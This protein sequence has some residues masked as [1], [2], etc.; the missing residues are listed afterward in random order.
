MALIEDFR[1]C[2]LDG[3]LEGALRL[4]QQHSREL[5][6]SRV[7]GM[8]VL[9]ILASSPQ[10][11]SLD[12]SDFV[13]AERFLE[14]VSL[15]EK[16]VEGQVLATKIK[17]PLKLAVE[18]SNCNIVWGLSR[19]GVNDLS[20]R[21]M[22]QIASTAP[23]EEVASC[24]YESYCFALLRSGKKNIHK[25]YEMIKS[26]KVSSQA[27]DWKGRGVFHYISENGEEY[28]SRLF[29]KFTNLG[30]DI[31]KR[32]KK[33]ETPL[34]VAVVSFF[35]ARPLIQSFKPGNVVALFME[36]ANF[37]SD[38]DGVTPI[39]KC[40]T[41]EKKELLASLVILH[42]VR[43]GINLD[44][45]EELISKYS[46]FITY[47][48]DDE[49]NVLHC[50]VRHISE[51]D[52]D[53][54]DKFYSVMR[55]LVRKLPIIDLLQHTNSE[56][57]TSMHMAASF[58]DIRSLQIM[59]EAEG[60]AVVSSKFLD[61]RGNTLLHSAIKGWCVSEY[62]ISTEQ[63][64]DV[65]DFLCEWDNSLLNSKNGKGRTPLHIA[66]ASN[67]AL[68]F[69][70]L[71]EMGASTEIEDNIGL[72]ALEMSRI[73]TV[74]LMME[75][76][77]LG[78]VG[79]FIENGLPN[80]KYYLRMGLSL[81]GSLSDGRT[82]L[83][84]ITDVILEHPNKIS[85]GVNF[86]KILARKGASTTIVDLKGRV[87]LPLSH[88]E[89]LAYAANGDIE[90]VLYMIA[91]L[92]TLSEVRD[93]KGNGIFHYI[94]KFFP[95]F[96]LDWI[97]KLIHKGVR[98]HLSGYS[99]D[100][101]DIPKIPC[102][103]DIK[104]LAFASI[105]NVEKV[106]EMLESG[107]VFPMVRDADGATILHYLASSGVDIA[108]QFVTNL[109][110][111]GVPLDVYTGSSGV[112]ALHIASQKSLIFARNLVIAG[113]KVLPD[114]NGV[115][116][117]DV[118][119]IFYSVALHKVDVGDFMSIESLLLERLIGK[120]LC[121]NDTTLLHNIIGKMF[122]FWI[123]PSSADDPVL[124]VTGS[125]RIVRLLVEKFPDML[126]CS[127]SSGRI[128]IH[129]AA[130]YGELDVFHILSV[131]YP[132]GVWKRD[133]DGNTALHLSLIGWKKYGATLYD[134]YYQVVE[135]ISQSMQIHH[136]LLQN[137]EGQN[138][139]HIASY[140]ANSEALSMLLGCDAVF[141]SHAIQKVATSI[142][143]DKNT[144]L[145]LAAKSLCHVKYV[146]EI[147]FSHNIVARLVSMYDKSANI[148]NKYG[149]TPTHLAAICGDPFLYKMLLE[150]NGNTEIRDKIG[151]TPGDYNRK[152]NTNK[153]M[154]E[155]NFLKDIQIFAVKD[156]Q[157]VNWY[158]NEG[159]ELTLRSWN[160]ETII[161]L[162]VNTLLRT[163][164]ALEKGVRLIRELLEEGANPN[165]ANFEEDTPLHLLIG[166][167]SPVSKS[168]AKVLLEYGAN[169]TLKSAN[170]YSFEDGLL[171]SPSDLREWYYL[172][173][174]AKEY[175]LDASKRC[176]YS[177]FLVTFSEMKSALLSLDK[178]EFDDICSDGLK[179]ALDFL[180]LPKKD[181]DDV[182]SH[183]G[184]CLSFFEQIYSIS[185]ARTELRHML[186]DKGLYTVKHLKLSDQSLLE[187]LDFIT[188]Q[189]IMSLNGRENFI[190]GV[191]ND[192]SEQTYQDTVQVIVK[193]MT[194]PSKNSLIYLNYACKSGAYEIVRHLIHQVK[195]LGKWHGKTPLIRA[196]SSGSLETVKILL[197]AKEL[198]VDIHMDVL[199]PEH[200]ALDLAVFRKKGA[201][202]QILLEHGAENA[203]TSLLE[204]PLLKLDDGR[205]IGFVASCLSFLRDI[206]NFAEKFPDLGMYT[207][208]GVDL[209]FQSSSGKTAVRIV[210]DAILSS[211]QDRQVI[212]SGMLLIQKLVHMG[213]EVDIADKHGNTPLCV[214]YCNSEVSLL[215]LRLGGD[216]SI[217][218]SSS[219]S[220]F[221]I[222]GGC[223]IM[224][225]SQSTD[226]PDDSY[227]DL[228]SFLSHRSLSSSNARTYLDYAC[229]LGA[230]DIVKVL[231]SK[232][233]NL[234]VY[235]DSTPLIRAV[236]SG[237]VSTVQ[238]ILNGADGFNLDPVINERVEGRGAAH[239]A[240]I[241]GEQLI[242][243]ILLENGADQTLL[244]SGGREPIDY[245]EEID[246][247]SIAKGVSFLK[248]ISS[249][250]RGGFSLEEEVTE[251]VDL[252]FRSSSGKAAIRIILDVIISDDGAMELGIRLIKSLVSAGAD[253]NAVDNEGITPLDSLA[254]NEQL[255]Q[256]LVTLGAVGKNRAVDCN[257]SSMGKSGIP[258]DDVDNAFLQKDTT[259]LT[260]NP[261]TM[262]DPYF[263][264]ITHLSMT[265]LT[266]EMGY[267]ARY[268]Q[269]F[270]L[271]SS[272]SQENSGDASVVMGNSTKNLGDTSIGSV[273]NDFHKNLQKGRGEYFL[274]HAMEK[275]MLLFLFA[276]LACSSVEG[277]K[278]VI[279]ENISPVEKLFDRVP[280]IKEIASSVQSFCQNVNSNAAV[281][282]DLNADEIIQNYMNEGEDVD[283]T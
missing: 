134:Q 88:L 9:D 204:D 194:P 38:Y 161:G 153:I 167:K 18:S 105:G 78:K 127:D 175:L 43:R 23:S 60:F 101:E 98:I 133:R 44:I 85:D 131:G 137:K 217:V 221:D 187:Q 46:K 249:F 123:D 17:K 77:F 54:K 122:D 257:D 96:P 264:K 229:I 247:Y 151:K 30:C 115:S 196:V 189:Q 202:Y 74:E 99:E 116:P 278:A 237:S 214:T 238:V 282:N 36:G 163:P 149:Q 7:E 95:E 271:L 32:D 104:C 68:S 49:C 69:K 80:I 227:I 13:L 138:P 140:N 218:D 56:G 228:V 119:K 212:V 188:K 67:N 102:A 15:L 186:G 273:N 57:I 281:F 223:I 251:G 157:A 199:D 200:N 236:L 3:D 82:A 26:G 277:I 35:D 6:N 268:I 94:A 156:P 182:V 241:R 267:E 125:K 162:V 158:K 121:L 283:F 195:D 232:V 92:P 279:S 79:N 128:P 129:L 48:P 64:Y 211:S 103:K 165:L 81:D 192:L 164:K 235:H 11:S 108:L 39:E 230:Q 10:I 139:F 112:T 40:N 209:N 113:A 2:A 250:T 51:S 106:L 252:D 76:I 169:P 148:Q 184:I 14:M 243:K 193:H 66:A 253:I 109:V 19:I 233:E 265:N 71:L 220:F 166:S 28:S 216:P 181:M 274:Q 130:L 160:G 27:E 269:Y 198:G 146:N 111:L 147:R 33:G 242:F 177:P 154:K 89:C 117:K 8:G 4:L 222:L 70:M 34:H 203:D 16:G 152:V 91:N 47:L 159:I 52:G 246:A 21:N 258:P 213:A 144:P 143:K 224:V 25:A 1:S 100:R 83:H 132:D 73:N 240:A 266:K 173:K 135:L 120:V 20:S 259:L 58:L 244:D 171:Q 12:L 24:L 41:L 155:V 248:K 75:V 270:P 145:H 219:R 208:K 107:E 31:N 190:A 226:T 261:L 114:L 55:L 37:L 176:D 262:L 272:N 136:L 124:Y 50:L 84:I 201:I 234:E 276:K 239:I 174:N 256:E 170:G 231:L 179:S 183:I 93:Y 275:S 45:V 185:Q 191:L 142:D 53:T 118:E 263:E 254:C 168:I 180:F 86:I 42:T 90:K 110:S 72:M 63:L 59:K 255:F 172:F 215:L 225:L 197:D 62:L 97:E 178:K 65:V 22:V 205:S 260:P 5:W 141:N 150:F 207:G 210:V 61:D 206:A 29:K 245:N 126:H 87:P 280:F